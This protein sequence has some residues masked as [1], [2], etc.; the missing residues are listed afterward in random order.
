MSNGGIG[1]PLFDHTIPSVHEKAEGLRAAPP[2]PLFPPVK[3]FSSRFLNRSKRR[4]SNGGIEEP[5]F[6]HTIKSVNEWVEA[7]RAAPPFPLFAPVKLFALG[8]LNRR[9]R[10]V[11]KGGIEELFFDHTIK[12]VNEW[13][14][15]LRAAPPFPLFPPV[16]LF[17]L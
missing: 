9:Q 4:V 15:G 1:E 3:L 7:L 11:S 8:L 14:E 6:G 13:A 16:Q 10:R 17:S 5:L 12:S 2:F